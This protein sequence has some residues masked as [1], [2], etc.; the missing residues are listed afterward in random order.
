MIAGEISMSGQPNIVFITTDQQNCSTIGGY[1]GA[2]AE[3]PNLDRLAGEGLLLEHAYVTCPLCVPSRASM[4]SGRYPHVSGI[5]LNDDGREIEYPDGIKGLSDVLAESGY[6]C[7]YF[8]K[9]HLGR[10][11]TAQ[12]GFSDG[13]ETFLRESYED[14]LQESGRFVFEKPLTQHRRALV[15]EALAHDT[16]V[17]E[18][19]MEYIRNRRGEKP[20][21]LWCALRAPHDPYVGPYTD[22]YKAADMQLPANVVDD[23]RGKPACQKS[24]WSEKYTRLV[25]NVLTPDD[26]RPV[27]A[28]YQGLSY[29]VD[30][31]VG[32]ILESLR[33]AGLEDDT[34]VVFHSDHGDM[35]GAHG[36]ITKGPYMYEETNRVPFIIRY[37]GRIPAG[38][39]MA[40]LFSLVDIAPTILDLAGVSHSESFDGI[41]AAGAMIEASEHFRE[42]VFAETFEIID[43]RCLLLS[44]RT[45][46][47]K[48]N[49]YFGDM[50]ELYDMANDPL[51]M[52][53]LAEESFSVAIVREM[54]SRLATWLAETGGIDMVALLGRMT[55]DRPMNWLSGQVAYMGANSI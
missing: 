13:W 47:W 30:V 11:G 2:N 16:Y 25:E 23:F 34:I 52:R 36:L 17:T 41:S 51:E 14:S 18:R 15:P 29:Y 10:D 46:K 37:P 39:K 26:L 5:M 3:T 55:K 40:G 19:S 53:N 44:V 38:K 27:I 45:E 22:R 35:M 43:Q 20:F 12:H 1:G 7:A 50:D 6:D 54:Q 28:R 21:A 32:R 24:S 8:G 31:N 48:Y 33:Q 42:A 49:L 4:M 9:W